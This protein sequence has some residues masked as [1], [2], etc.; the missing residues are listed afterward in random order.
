MSQGLQRR[1]RPLLSLWDLS[2]RNA[3]LS[4]H[5]QEWTGQSGQS[6]R[7]GHTEL[8]TCNLYTGVEA[9]KHG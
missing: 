5:G 1:L 6:N 3:S 9:V 2:V 8:S 7:N 4:Q